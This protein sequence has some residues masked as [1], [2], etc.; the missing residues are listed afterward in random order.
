MSF[1]TCLREHSCIEH[2]S[3]IPEMGLFRSHKITNIDGGKQTFFC[4]QDWGKG[5]KSIDE[6][7]VKSYLDSSEP[8]LEKRRIEG[9][10]RD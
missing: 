3:E 7:P 4:P 1:G 6:R 5:E 2:T 10:Q 8:A 9:R